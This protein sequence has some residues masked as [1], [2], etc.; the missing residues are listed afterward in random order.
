MLA[1]VNGY[2]ANHD[3]ADLYYSKSQ[4]RDVAAAEVVI[5]VGIFTTEFSFLPDDEFENLTETVTIT[6][7]GYVVVSKYLVGDAG[8]SPSDSAARLYYITIDGRGL[9]SSA[10]FASS[11]AEANVRLSGV[12][13]AP[14]PAGDHEVGVGVDCYAGNTGS[15]ISETHV[16]NAL[17]IVLSS[18]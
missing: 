4:V 18:G 7:T 3:H 14:V 12:T 10:V 1:D 6:K 5:S 9:P 13:E 17:V 11:S 15:V 16:T 8:C 2:Y